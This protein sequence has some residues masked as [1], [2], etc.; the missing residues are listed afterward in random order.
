MKNKLIKNPEQHYID[1]VLDNIRDSDTREINDAY[2]MTPKEAFK[3]LSVNGRNIHVAVDVYGIPFMLF[4]STMHIDQEGHYVGVPFLVAT[5]D[6]KKYSKFLLSIS[7][8]QLEAMKPFYSYLIN[9]VPTYNKKTIRWLS[10]CGFSLQ[11][12]GFCGYNKNQEFMQFEMKG[13]IC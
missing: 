7:K 2:G 1:Y 5:K 10:W 12:A 6:I 13:G 3:D 4:G 8:E 9:W 11:P